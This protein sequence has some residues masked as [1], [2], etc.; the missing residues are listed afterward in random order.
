MP[1]TSPI[2]QCHH[3]RCHR[4]QLEAPGVE[5]TPSLSVKTNSNAHDAG[6]GDIFGPTV[7]QTFVDQ[8]L[9]RFAP[10][11]NK[12]LTAITTSHRPHGSKG[13]NDTSSHAFEQRDRKSGLPRNESGILEG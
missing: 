4:L 5:K 12:R 11:N 6:N 1:Y 7:M 2:R 3:L 9:A 13:N 10:G 8:D